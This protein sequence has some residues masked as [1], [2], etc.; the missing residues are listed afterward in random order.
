MRILLQPRNPNM[1]SI[2]SRQTQEV[3]NSNFRTAKADYF[4]ANFMPLLQ[5]LADDPNAKSSSGKAQ[6]KEKFTRF[7]DLLD[8]VVERHRMAKVLDEDE[9]GR[10]TVVEEVVKLVVPS[11]QRFTQKNREKEFSKSEFPH[12]I[13]YC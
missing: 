1:S 2:L 8:E 5:T 7:F 11:L 10:D 12:F 4:N 6:T 9:E 13:S 3:L